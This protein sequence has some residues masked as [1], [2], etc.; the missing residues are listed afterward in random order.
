MPLSQFPNLRAVKDARN[1][2]RL[3]EAVYIY[4]LLKLSEL[5]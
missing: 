4:W 5:K 3:P 2:M 1:G